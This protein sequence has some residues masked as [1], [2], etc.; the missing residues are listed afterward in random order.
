[1]RHTNAKSGQCAVR[2]PSIVRLLLRSSIRV[3]SRADSRWTEVAE[4]CLTRPSHCSRFPRLA[5]VPSSANTPPTSFAQA[6]F[7]FLLLITTGNSS[8]NES[9]GGLS[10]TFWSGFVHPE[11]TA[12]PRYYFTFIGVI[13]GPFENEKKGA[14]TRVRVVRV[15]RK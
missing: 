8:G 2:S 7:S 10:L 5:P 1:M 11:Q 3:T 14:T 15:I 4:R 12:R 13:G 6:F 9:R